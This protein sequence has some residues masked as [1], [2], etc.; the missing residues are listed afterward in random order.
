MIHDGDMVQLKRGG[1]E[2]TRAAF[3]AAAG[4][5]GL[6]GGRYGHFADDG[7]AFVITDPDAPTPWTNVVCAGRY[8]FVVSHNGAGFSW[9]DDAQHNVLTRWEMDLVRDDRGK[10]LYVIDLDSREVWSAAPAPCRPAY[11]AYAC[12]HAPG[13]T[14]FR[15]RCN[16][17][18]AEWVMGLAPDSTAELWSVRITNRSARPRRLRV[19]SYL[20]WC[21]GVAPDSKREFHKLFLR[22]RYDAGRRAIVAT[23]TMWDLPGGPEASHWNRPWPYA[24]AHAVRGEA[25]EPTL[26]IDDK[27]EFLGRYGSP[28]RPAALGS[29][30]PGVGAAAGRQGDAIAAL[31]GDLTLE[32]GAG[33]SLLYILAIAEDEASLETTLDR[34]PTPE[35]GEAALRASAE[36]WRGALAGVRV[37]SAWPD[38]DA[39]NNTW[40]PYQAQSARLHG[41]TGYYQQ[42][43]ARGFRDQLQDS[44]VWL[45]TAPERTLD[46][47]VRHAARQFTTGAVQHWWHELA[48]FG[49]PTTCSDDLLWMPFVM[50]NYLRETGDL[51]A[52]DRQ[53][54][55][56]DSG[57]SASLLEHC[58]RALD[59]ADR[60]RSPRGLP[61]IG[62]CDWNDGLSAVGIEGR[63]ES[64]WLAFFEI[65]LLRDWQEIFLRAGDPTA[66]AAAVRRHDALVEAVNA[67]AWDGEWF[68]RATRDDGR[69]LGA[70]ACTEGSIYLNPQVWA[71]MADATTPERATAAW[72]STKDHLLTDY[73]PLL[74]AP[75]YATPDASIG[76][77]TRYP[78]GARENGGVYTHAATWALAAAC[79]RR[80]PQTVASIWRSLSPILRWAKDADVYAAEPFVLPGNSDGPLAT[81]PGRA[82]WT[83]YTGSAAWLHRISLEWVLGIRPTWEGLR[84]DPCPAPDMGRVRVRRSWR[85]CELLIGFD[86]SEFA[87]GAR[88]VV[89]ADGRRLDSGLLRP[90]DIEGKS[91][92]EVTVSWASEPA[93]PAAH[94]HRGRTTA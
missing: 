54:P 92:L 10:F 11:Q 26:A 93:T 43:G 88:A 17:I 4:A 41:R 80:E 64:V 84:I 77:I 13:Q 20:E 39:L 67:H 45:A 82:G 51:A 86:A 78:P 68:R 18:E 19:C 89:H 60:R 90:G 74:L 22:T 50:A 9:L 1:S 27:T 47:I 76:Y 57:E 48:D 61:L 36:A 94:T 46:Q 58:R 91:T 30:P 70:A 56:L 44:Q 83:W 72:E 55:F 3:A 21:C 65:D 63:G 5:A 52:L 73:G 34:F 79:K 32:P 31:G 29:P 62:S 7:G 81:T 59:L 23:R 24:A 49:N 85:G 40:L 33:A 12:E 37:Q 66:A 16:D 75:A 42:S 71:I 87:P 2:A 8:G 28:A 38:F 69:W 53:A 25:L 6:P 35:S 15:T 14:T